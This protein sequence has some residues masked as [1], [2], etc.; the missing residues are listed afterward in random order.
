MKLVR[1]G[2]PGRE[3][4]GVIDGEGKLRDLSRK[5]KEIGG[6]VLAPGE[7]A[8]L[9]KLDT[10]KLPQV[11]GRPRLGPCIATP[12]KF[13]AIGL[14]YIDHAK[15][16]GNPIPEYPVVFYKAETCIVGA[17]D[18]IMLPPDSTHTDWEVEL[19]VVIGRKARYVSAG[20]ALKYVAGYCVVNDV[21]ERD[22]QL[23]KGGSQWSKG[24][25][26]DTFGPIGPWLVT[27]DE[28]RDPQNLDMWLDVNGARRQTGNTRTMIFGV[29]ALVADLSKCM[30]LLPGDVI[31]TGTPPGVGMGMKPEPQYLK[32]GDVVT[33]GIAGLGEQRQE[34]VAFRR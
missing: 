24:K 23:K 27:T 28:I 13:V 2:P 3:K 18:K 9:R 15:E 32:P 29:A 31:T 1:Y 7:L 8:K 33:L 14:N 30:T 26:C 21:S 17:N 34:V 20:D 12:S 25:G 11:K 10:K 19:G 5:V 16:S 4:P 6:A 22:Y